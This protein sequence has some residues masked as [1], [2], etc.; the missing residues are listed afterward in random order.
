[1][2]LYAFPNLHILPHIHRHVRTPYNSISACG[3]R[4]NGIW[5]WK[6]VNLLTERRISNTKYYQTVNIQPAIRPAIQ[7]ATTTLRQ[8]MI[9]RRSHLDT[10]TASTIVAGTHACSLVT[11]ILVWLPHHICVKIAILKIYRIRNRTRNEVEMGAW[12][13]V[14]E[15]AC[16]AARYGH[17]WSFSSVSGWDSKTTHIRFADDWQQ[18]LILHLEGSVKNSLVPRLEI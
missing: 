6:E 17:L 5:V 18:S 4:T 9:M 11:W 14:K 10:M 13:F 16:T 7:P 12:R 3:Q 15:K 1:M 2:T 8:D